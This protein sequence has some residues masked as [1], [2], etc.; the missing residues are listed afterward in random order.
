MIGGKKNAKMKGEDNKMMSMFGVMF[1]RLFEL[2]CWR[3]PLLLVL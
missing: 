1:L 2:L 3:S